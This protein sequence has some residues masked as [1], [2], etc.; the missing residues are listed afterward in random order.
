[1]TS[2]PQ[3]LTFPSD[4][5]WGAATAS[6]QIEGA[7][8]EDGRGL[9]IWDTFC[10]APGAV[11]NGDTGDVACDHYHRYPEDIELMRRI[12][13]KAYRFSIAWPRIIPQGTGSINSAGL[14]FYDRLVDTLLAAGIT[15]YAT[16]YHWDLPQPLQD[17]GGWPNR[18]TIDAFL[19]YT[20]VIT[21]RLGDRVKNWMT[22]NE[23]LVIAY[24]GY[25]FGIHAPGIRDMKAGF[26]AAHH[27]LLAHG[28]AVPII[29][30]NSPNSRAGIVLNPNWVD[31]ASD[32][33]AD[34]AAAHIA[35][36]F[37]NRWFLDPVLKGEYPA[38]ILN[39]LGDN[40]PK[41]DDG[42][43]KAISVPIDFLG[44]NYYTRAVVAYDPTQE[45]GQRW[46]HPEGE[47][48]AMDWEVYPL[49]LYNLLMRL[50]NEYNAPPL[51]ITENGAA[52]EDVVTP[53][54]EICDE[55][56]QAYLESH[57]AAC[58]R[59]IQDGVPLK[60]YFVWSLLDNFEW[61]YGY[62]RRFGITYVDYTT[63][64]RTLK[65]SGEWYS[66]TAKANGF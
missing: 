27:V 4:F 23:P 30:A 61:A 2:Q 26:Q 6:F 53:D 43:L 44:I 39:I 32:S 28:Q 40:A 56:R 17:A 3:K 47:Y 49:G 52:Y 1:M 63:L 62:S 14:D 20:D 18:A 59:A 54:G 51:Y 22:I 42:D 36:G 65:Q 15:P 12:G 33:D 5:L 13:V 25:W 8:D 24:L 60:G 50:K 37:N 7:Y 45:G 21:H 10:R 35:D 66:K 16:L 29:R 46:E 48:T 41:V 31:P 58:H 11:L 34:K 55:R 57:L 19:K 38:D 64:K 9:S